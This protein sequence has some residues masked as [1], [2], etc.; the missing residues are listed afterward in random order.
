MSI[1]D[2]YTIFKQYPHISTDT[3]SIEQDALYFALKGN[4]FNGND[5]AL[6]AL[7][8]G[9]KYAIVDEVIPGSNP[10]IIQVNNVLKCL[11]DL[12]HHHR[13]QF[14]IPVLGITG[15]NG[16]TTSKELI[17]AV[18]SKK[19]NTLAT[20]GN[21]NNHI[22]VPLTL[23]KI[24]SDHEFAI[25]EMGANHPGEIE[26]L[27]QIANPNYGL[28]TNVGH[29]HLEGFGSFENIISTKSA[30]YQHVKNIS[31]INF[32]LEENLEINNYL[33]DT[34]QFVKY[35]CQNDQIANFGFGDDK[36]IF[37]KLRIQKLNSED[38][39]FEIQTHLIGLYNQYN[40]MAAVTIGNYFNISQL[41]TIEA[42]ESYQPN[43]NRSQLKE[44]S[45]NRLILDAYNANP[46]SVSEAILNFQKL[47]SPKKILILGDMFELG[48][49][50]SSEHQ[51][52]V[53]LLLK[54]ETMRTILIGDAFYKT[55]IGS[56]KH[57]QKFLNIEDLINEKKLESIDQALVLLKGSRGM[58]LERLVDFL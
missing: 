47:D 11:Q 33:G 44:S 18:L 37:L 29:A 17:L 22:G 48:A 39:S 52:I 30:L 19:Y 58:R 25:I 26:D 57:I 28:V 49:F 14:D 10:N 20:L 23:L 13:M 42:L 46:S 7:D 38:S 41:D 5:F 24:N 8:S 12:A 4:N 40:L 53:D 15:T 16:K 6:Q 21:F 36:S 55:T 35:S 27:C 50:S 45:R 54:A 56:S 31:G 32:F 2:L 51:A 3:R 9:A 1:S 34:Y 43:N